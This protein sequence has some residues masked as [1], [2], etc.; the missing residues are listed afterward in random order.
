MALLKGFEKTKQ[1]GENTSKVL[2]LLEKSYLS[3]TTTGEF[4]TVEDIQGLIDTYKK[5]PQDNIDVQTK[6]ADL[7]GKKLQFN[8]KLTDIL[9]QKTVFDSQLQEGLDNAAKNNFKNMKSLIGSYAS[10]YADADE[11]YDSEVMSKI[12][13]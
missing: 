9:S 7:E 8:S 10:I 1:D 2:N 11:R 3:K 13:V 6:I 5:L 4:N 12:C